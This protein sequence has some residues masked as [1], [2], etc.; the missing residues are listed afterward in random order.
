M[1]AASGAQGAP[2][3]FDPGRRWDARLEAIRLCVLDVDGTLLTSRHDVSRA[4][5]AAVEA[6]HAAGLRVLLASSRS[7]SALRPVLEGLGQASGT[8]FVA[9]QGAVLGHFTEDG[10]LRTGLHTP[11]PLE[12]ARAVARRASAL[13]LSVSWYSLADWLVPVLDELVAREA[14]ITRCR[15]TVADLDTQDRGPDKLMLISPA[16][17]IPALASLAADLPPSLRGQ[18]SHANYLEITAAT[19]DKASAVA[20]FCR[21]QDLTSAQVLAIG[22][23]PNDRGLLELAGV[24]V[25][26]RNARADVPAAADLRTASNDDDGV[27]RVLEHLVRLRGRRAAHT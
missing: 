1:R 26:P 11:A 4:T 9:S 25:A 7:P 2:L 13:G 15:P 3:M 10:T 18:L 19:V 8:P 20:T 21:E 12:D 6:A 23:G 24:G 27:A 22:D 16:D 5:R 14:A 17:S